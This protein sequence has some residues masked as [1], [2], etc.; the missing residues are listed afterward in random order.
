MDSFI[1]KNKMLIA[2]SFAPVDGS[3][4]EPTSAFCH[5]SYKRKG[6]KKWSETITLGKNPI[7][8]KWTGVWDSS[9]AEAGEV[10]WVA[11][12]A[13][14]VVGATQGTFLIEANDANK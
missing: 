4:D 5:L 7:T 12:S 10:D 11:E 6:G 8:G 2:V 9:K 1:R 14:P 13:G 3:S